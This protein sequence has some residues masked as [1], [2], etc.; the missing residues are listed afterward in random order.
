MPGSPFSFRNLLEAPDLAGKAV[1]SGAVGRETSGKV[2][3]GQGGEA[4]GC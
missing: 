1:G 2:G 3:L 4:D